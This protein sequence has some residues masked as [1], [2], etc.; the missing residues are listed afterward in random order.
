MRH[1]LET[2]TK[3][4]FLP[5]LFMQNFRENFFEFSLSFIIRMLQDTN[6]QLEEAK[7][8]IRRLSEIVD[9]QKVRKELKTYSTYMS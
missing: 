5:R 4:F 7:D 2:T 3:Y 1:H 8:R 9:S 6:Q